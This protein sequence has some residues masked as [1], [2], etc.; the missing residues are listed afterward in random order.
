LTSA[1]HVL[2]FD[3]GTSQMK[4]AVV[5]PHGEAEFAAT[6]ATRGDADPGSKGEV[7]P[8][9]IWR[10]LVGAVRSLPEALRARTTTIVVT[11]Q[12]A[13][14]FLDRDGRRVRNAITWQDHRAEGQAR[15]LRERFPDLEITARRRMAADR[16]ASILVWLRR[17]E[18]DV[19]ARTETVFHLKDYV[20]YRL[21][22]QIT[23]DVVH[24]AYTGLFDVRGL[25][26]DER[27]LAQLGF[28]HL[29]LGRLVSPCSIIGELSDDAAHALGLAQNVKVVAGGPDGTMSSIGAGAVEAG[30]VSDVGGTS[31]VV[32]ACKEDFPD[33]EVTGL[34]VNPHPDAQRWFVGGPMSSTGLALEWVS[35]ILHCPMDKIGDLAAGSPPGAN[36]VL[37]VPTLDGSRTPD[38]DA[39]ARGAFVGLSLEHTASD[40]ARAAYEGIAFSIRRLID[41]CRRAGCR[42]DVALLTGGASR[43]PFFCQ[44]KANCF[45][46]TAKSVPERELGISG[47]VAC[48]WVAQ[49]THPDL[50]DAVSH[51]APAHTRVYQ[52][53]K[54]E[55][56]VYRDCFARY[57]K[58]LGEAAGLGC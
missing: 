58:H 7:D 4:F 14:C 48:A 54:A 1:S 19:Y 37:F 39:C 27:L 24:A 47:S 9:V 2:A 55:A 52:V 3:I 46:V 51:L 49:G 53:I 35:R 42:V 5:G 41:L 56:S 40:L 29:R 20:N 13:T 23:T 25:R 18:A 6:V 26:F 11:C 44:L 22:G 16:A 28:A 43:D 21:T 10:S 15:E 45:G 32:F 34:V 30:S 12:L 38:W 33:S 8:D 50:A 31:E 17:H 36:G 57:E